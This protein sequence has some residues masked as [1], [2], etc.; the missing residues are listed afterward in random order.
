[1][2][3]VG[4]RENKVPPHSHSAIL[5][6][7]GIIEQASANR[8]LVVPHG[9]PGTGVESEYIVGSRDIHETR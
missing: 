8:T 7:R 2:G 4:F 1:M 6:S 5:M 3:I 9:S